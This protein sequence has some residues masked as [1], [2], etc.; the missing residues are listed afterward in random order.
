[1]R[2]RP[3]SVPPVLL[4]APLA[5]GFA[6]A[7]PAAAAPGVEPTPP[8]SAI[9][10]VG[11]HII[12]V[13]ADARITDASGLAMGGTGDVLFTHQDAAR[14]TDVYGL[15]GRGQTRF[16][17]SLPTGLNED[18]EDIS[19]V[20][21]ADGG[22]H[23]Y[24]GDLGDG[25]LARR[26]TGRTPRTRFRL[27]RFTEPNAQST[28]A[29]PATGVQVHELAYSDGMRGRNAETLLVQPGAGHVFVADKTEKAGLK[30]RLWLAKAPLATDRVN[31]LRPVVDS[32]PVQGA[33]GGAFSPT[34]DRIVIRNA[35]T[36]Y[37]WWIRNGN[38]AKSLTDPPIEIPLPRQRQG[39]GVTFTADGSALVINSEGSRQP[40]WQ[41]PLPGRANSDIAEPATPVGEAGQANANTT[42]ALG[43][44][45]GGVATA[46]GVVL[47]HLWRRT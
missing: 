26:Q 42:L 40:I 37:L 13:V 34:G 45:G 27:V 28:G 18:W 9:G 21:L 39:E 15:D 7:G 4:A 29:V 19:T 47:F 20:R 10:D 46:A 35:D 2:I 8:E 36:A 32:L 24:V 17:V 25:F 30:A 5:L 11:S 44:F 23:V 12:S 33:S 22:R 38:V 14:S 31:P 6:L 41:V 3:L 16:T 1:M 43:I